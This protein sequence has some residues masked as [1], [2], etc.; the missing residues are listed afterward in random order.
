MNKKLTYLELCEK[1]REDVITILIELI[2]SID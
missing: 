2:E 1:Y